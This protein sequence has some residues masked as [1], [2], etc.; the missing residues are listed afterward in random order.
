MYCC[1]ISGVAVRTSED[2]PRYLG[3]DPYFPGLLWI[4]D[5]LSAKCIAHSYCKPHVFYIE[6]LEEKGWDKNGINEYYYSLPPPPPQSKSCELG[7]PEFLTL[8]ITDKS[9][10]WLFSTCKTTQGHPVFHASKPKFGI[11]GGRGYFL[12]GWQN[13]GVCVCDI[14]NK[15]RQHLP[16]PTPC[17]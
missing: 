5:A 2:E 15:Q 9:Q 11:G 4:S 10:V 7:I 17:L 16:F 6:K 13:C 8:D 14:F 3:S 1:W 12:N